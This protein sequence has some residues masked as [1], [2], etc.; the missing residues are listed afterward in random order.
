VWVTQDE[1]ARMAEGLGLGVDE[2]VRL[3]VRRVGLRRSL[4]EL[5]GGDCVLWGGADRGC[6]VHGARPTQ[7]RT[8]PF[9]KQHLKSR[10][11]WDELAAT[12]PGIGRGPLHSAKDIRKKLAKRA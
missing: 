12:C 1:I 9:W 8:F 11:T 10:R 6:L 5:P 3:H 7:C 2:F 4:K